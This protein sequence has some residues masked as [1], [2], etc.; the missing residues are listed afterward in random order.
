MADLYHAA[1]DEE[2]EE[3]TLGR[4]IYHA[5]L[6]DRRGF[7]PDQIGIPEDDPV[8]CEIFSAMGIAAI[9]RI[10]GWGASDNLK[11]ETA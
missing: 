9:D 2:P 11:G 8:W 1:E 6:A 5:A 3:I 7:R 10:N 4:A